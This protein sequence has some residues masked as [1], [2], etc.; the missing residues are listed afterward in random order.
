MDE[1]LNP[2][3]DHLFDY[4]EKS[5]TIPELISKKNLTKLSTK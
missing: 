3:K 2:I 5:Q 1:Q 4:I